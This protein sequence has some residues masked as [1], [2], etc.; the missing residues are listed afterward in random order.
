MIASLM[1]YARPELAEAHHRLWQLIRQQLQQVGIES[2]ALLSQDAEEFSVWNDPGLVLSQ[3]CGMPYRLMLHNNVQL[4]GT[5]NYAIE[6]CKPGYYRSAL[7]VR[8]NDERERIEHFENATF[9]Y[10]QTHSQSG[11]AAPYFHTQA[12]KFWFQK[13]LQTHQHRESAKAVAKGLADIVR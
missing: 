2:P 10:N 8:K 13:R 11:Y 12:H 1:M 6:G 3:T 5:P 9:A 4:V 7:V